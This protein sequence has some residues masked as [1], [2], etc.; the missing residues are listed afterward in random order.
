MGTQKFDRDLRVQDSDRETRQ[1]IA[2]N[3]RKLSSSGNLQETAD[4]YRGLVAQLCDR[5][6]VVTCKDDLQWILQRR[7]KG[8]AERPWRGVGYFRT[9][10]AL[11]RVCASLC[12][13]IDPSALAI[14]AALPG[15]IGRST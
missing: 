9:R 13:R 2:A 10:E 11:I 5:H 4:Q 12:S 6:R 3:S 8:G 1:A 15:H 7:K 14:L